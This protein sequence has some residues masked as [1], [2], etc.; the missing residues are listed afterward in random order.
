MTTV[1][2]AGGG[3]VVDTKGAPEQVLALCTMIRR[4]GEDLPVTAA[5]REQAARVMTGYARRG[6]RVLAF[7]CRALPAGAAVPGRR[8]D[9][10]RDLCLTGLAAML[11]PPRPEVPAAIEPT[12]PAS[13]S[14]WSPV[15]TG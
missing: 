3:L 10:E 7:A 12:R 2:Q 4:G 15:T 8:Q 6:L 9:A 5:D 1:D 13:R 14:T 11:D